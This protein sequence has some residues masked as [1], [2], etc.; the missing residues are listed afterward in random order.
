LQSGACHESKAPQ[1]ADTENARVEIS[2]IASNSVKKKTTA[3]PQGIWGGPHVILTVSESGATLEFDCA[4]GAIDQEIVLD[5][6][7]RFEVRGTYEGEA[8]AATDISISKEDSSG[9]S[10]AAT[11][12]GHPARYTGEVNGRIMT[13]TATLSDTATSLGPFTLK[14]GATPRLKKCL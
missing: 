6:N 7:D 13:L 5:A 2:P 8:S 14:S 4:H 12:T 11:A 3:L 10:K 9:V 1:T